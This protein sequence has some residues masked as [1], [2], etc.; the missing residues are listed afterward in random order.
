M[1]NHPQA[2]SV[3]F[4]I[5]DGLEV[6]YPQ[7][8]FTVNYAKFLFLM[9][10]VLNLLATIALFFAT[11]LSFPVAMLS[12]FFIFLLGIL[13]DFLRKMAIS[14]ADLIVQERQSFLGF[15]YEKY[16]DFIHFLVPNFSQYLAFD[17]ITTGKLISWVTI[18]EAVIFLILI[19]CGL[20]IAIGCH[21]F[22]RR[23]VAKP[24]L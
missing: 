8:S 23:E 5:E 1:D 7:S 24:L 17:S 4:P 3:F 9:F 16:F 13:L 10:I 2:G 15:V 22:F 19:D 21:V 11:F 12:S 6:L 18:A 14:G 20:L